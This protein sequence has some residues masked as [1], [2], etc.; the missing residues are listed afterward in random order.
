MNTCQPT[1]W[2]GFISWMIFA[3]FIVAIMWAVFHYGLRY[4]DG[5]RRKR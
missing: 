2:E 4:L 3:I 1:Y 5:D